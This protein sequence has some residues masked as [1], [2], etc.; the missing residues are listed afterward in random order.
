MHVYLEPHCIIPKVVKNLS[1]SYKIF[2]GVYNGISRIDDLP[3]I[4]ITNENIGRRIYTL[5]FT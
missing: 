1:L 2:N 5:N 3:Q 4:E